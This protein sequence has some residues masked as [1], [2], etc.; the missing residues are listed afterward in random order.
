MESAFPITTNIGIGWGLNYC[1]SADHCNTSVLV[2]SFN[3]SVGLFYIFASI[4]I[5][6]Y[7]NPW[8][9]GYWVVGQWF[10]SGAY[11]ASA[12]WQLSSD[13]LFKFSELFSLWRAGYHV[14]LRSVPKKRVNSQKT[15][16]A[17]SL[18]ANAIW[19][20]WNA[21]SFMPS[22]ISPLF[23]LQGCEEISRII[24]KGAGTQP[25]SRLLRVY[26][27]NAE[28]YSVMTRNRRGSLQRKFIGDSNKLNLVPSRKFKILM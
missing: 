15:V 21:I 28:R 11:Y 17:C 6:T 25:H 20:T 8:Y 3:R 13:Y 1:V 14:C 22:I 18:W 27:Q 10:V 7:L 2:G 4:A 9:D 19:C 16:V 26:P 12:L 23:P 5:T 24:Q